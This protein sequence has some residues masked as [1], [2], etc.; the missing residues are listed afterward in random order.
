M[1][2]L[3]HKLIACGLLFAT[4]SGTASA[5][6]YHHIDELACAISQQTKQLVFESRHYRHTPEYCHLSEDT[7]ELA[8]L[9]D[10]IHEL[11]IHRGC[12][13]QLEADV[14]ALDATFHHLEGVYD[15]VEYAASMGYGRIR[16]CTVHVK[17]L[18]EGIEDN[19][20]HL[21]ADLR[22]L[23][24]AACQP[25]PVAAPVAV[26]RPGFGDWDRW[27]SDRW[28][29]DRWGGNRFGGYNVPPPRPVHHGHDRWGS[30]PPRGRTFSIGGGSSRITF[31]F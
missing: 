23:R 4:M 16:G 20:H 26:R 31:R 8:R 21:Q 12:I 2:A 1:V 5:D 24:A 10:H 19:I 25:V 28:G 17:R 7:R 6:T 3:H 29:G 9:A 14:D 13:T 11:A 22:I 18:L 30:R 27:P 15:R